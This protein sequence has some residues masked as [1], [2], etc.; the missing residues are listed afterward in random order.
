MCVCGCAQVGDVLVGNA[1]RRTFD[2]VNTGGQGRF[3]LLPA[4]AW[5]AALQQQGQQHD[6]AHGPPQRSSTSGSPPPPPAAAAAV[7]EAAGQQDDSSGGAL[8][9][10]W[11]A[12]QQQLIAGPFSI[13]PTHLDLPAGGAG[14]LVVDFAPTEPGHTHADLV[15]LCDHCTA[16][17]LRV[18]GCGGQVA[19]QLAAL[20]GRPWSTQDAEGASAEPVWFGQVSSPLQGTGLCLGSSGSVLDHTAPTGG[21]L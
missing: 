16:H 3:L 18:E 1:R 8:G 17:T 2:F 7:G 13:S 19:L 9:V 14:C 10:S 15:L 5:A 11:A 6:G 21:Q 4:A 20:D 12:P